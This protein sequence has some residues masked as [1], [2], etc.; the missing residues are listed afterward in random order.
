MKRVNNNNNYQC[1][2]VSTE[3]YTGKEMSPKGLGYSAVGF[4]IGFEK[5]GVDKQLWSVQIKNGKKVWFRKSGM[6]KVSHEEPLITHDNKTNEPI[7][8]DEKPKEVIKEE[9]SEDSQKKTD[10]SIFYKY[11][12]NKLKDENKANGLDK[13]PKVIQ[14]ETYAEWARLKKNKVEMSELLL[15]IKNNR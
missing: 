3:T 6:S 14:E 4:D 9:K 7:N 10:F 15:L 2:N 13:K 5:E 1:V 8:T 12:S 11:Y